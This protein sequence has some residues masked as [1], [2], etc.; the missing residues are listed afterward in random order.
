MHPWSNGRQSRSN[1][2]A[3]SAWS[4][5]SW[6]LSA[7]TA[8]PLNVVLVRLM[9]PSSF[10]TYALATSISAFIVPFATFGL[11][12]SVAHQAAQ[13]LTSEEHQGLSMVARAATRVA[14]YLW[15]LRR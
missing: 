9:S 11:Q 3:G 5:A 10:G 6:L 13:A 2:L 4:L 8:F 15:C 7:A 1:I 12:G 14:V